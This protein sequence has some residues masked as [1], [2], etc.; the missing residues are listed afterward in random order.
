MIGLHTFEIE[1]CGICNA[2]CSYCTWQQREVGEKAMDLDMV[3]SLQDQL[4][5]MS[6]LQ[7][8]G[9]HGIGEATLH[10]DF[11]S[12][13]KRGAFL[14][15]PQR[16]STN[17]YTL[18][19]KIAE[20]FRTTDSLNLI[21]SVHWG[22]KESFLERCIEN[23]INYLKSWPINKSVIVL[24]VCEQSVEKHYQRFIDTFLPHIEELPNAMLHLKQPNTWPNDNP[25]FG[26]IRKDLIGN[27]NV[28]LDVRKTPMSLGKV[29]TQPNYFLLALSD[30]TYVPCCVGMDSSWN[31]GNAKDMTIMKAWNS[32]RMKEIRTLW[33]R[34]D[35]SIPCGQCLKRIDCI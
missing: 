19:G 5:E 26:F 6:N 2:N 17:A 28:I 9:L 15:L 3:L 4:M 13:L 12:I 16:V 24:M 20:A 18:R 1:L 25:N 21:L 27:P 32:E 11:I 34:A 8:V 7:F 30:G 29:C 22:L 10:P 14:G 35:D 23:I 31:I 33:R